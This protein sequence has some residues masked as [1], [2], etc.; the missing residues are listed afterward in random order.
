MDR[1]LQKTF[2]ARRDLIVKSV[3]VPG[4]EGFFGQVVSG[5]EVLATTDTPFQDPD[6]AVAHT[7]QILAQS[8]NYLPTEVDLTEKPI[9]TDYVQ[10]DRVQFEAGV[11]RGTGSICGRVDY[12][13]GVDWI[14]SLDHR[15]DGYDF[16]HIVIRGTCVKP[17]A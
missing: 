6:D 8:R 11:Y 15:I 16:S 7:Q 2:S 1:D 4:V 9:K 3:K 5:D 10:N 17:M 13:G 14:L 12:D